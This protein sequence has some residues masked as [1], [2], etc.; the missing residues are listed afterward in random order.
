MSY[1][2]IQKAGSQ[3]CRGGKRKRR[4]VSGEQSADR[5][6]P[7]APQLSPY[8]AQEKLYGNNQREVVRVVVKTQN[9]FRRYP[10]ELFYCDVGRRVFQGAKPVGD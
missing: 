4:N 6:L 5:Q 2:K 10:D 1:G 7:N 9:S 8:I 3:P